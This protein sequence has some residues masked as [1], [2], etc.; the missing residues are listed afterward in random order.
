MFPCCLPSVRWLAILGLTL[1]L[2][3]PAK[4]QDHSRIY[5]PEELQAD[6]ERLS[7]PINRLNEIFQDFFTTEEKAALKNLVIEF[8]Q[9]QKGDPALNF[10]AFSDFGEKVVVLPLMSL[11]MLE[12]V[13]TAYAYLLSSGLSPGTIDLYFT[14]LSREDPG[15]FPGGRYPALLPTLGVPADAWKHPPV[16]DLSLRLRNEAFAFVFLHEL[17]HIVLKHKSYEDISTS[18]ALTDEIAADRF[19]LDM[20]ER[21]KTPALGAALLFTAQAFSLPNRGQFD[22]DRAWI[23]FQHKKNTHPITTDR[24]RSFSD[25]VSNKL[26]KTRTAESEMWR[27]IGSGVNEIANNL[28]DPE[29]QKCMAAIR[30][31]GTL[32]DLAPRSGVAISLFEKLCL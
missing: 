17:G 2:G 16:D 1:L 10:Y 29:M 9:P 12:D 20:L 15:S 28:D 6:A 11:K 18:E 24:L 5:S 19:A 27:F 3:L 4:A 31:N 22:S 30:D 7:R 23:D 25:Y 14:M 8:P 32:D 13:T 21:T 26:S